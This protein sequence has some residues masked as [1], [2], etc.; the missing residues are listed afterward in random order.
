[1]DAR[2]KIVVRF[3]ATID[4]MTIDLETTGQA[5]AQRFREDLNL[6]ITE[7]T[8]IMSHTLDKDA[9]HIVAELE[10]AATAGTLH[11]ERADV[12]MAKVD[13]MREHKRF[14]YNWAHVMLTTRLMEVLRTLAWRLKDIVRKREYTGSELQRLAAE[15]EDR[16][17]IKLSNAPTGILFLEGMILAR[18]K[19]VHNGG[20]VWETVSN[21]DI[22]M[23][24]GEE[25]WKPKELDQDFK[26]R[27]GE[28][29]DGDRITS[30]EEVFGT[31]TKK[32]L[33]FT[34]WVTGQFDEFANLLTLPT[35]SR[36]S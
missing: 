7:T 14:V 13:N 11:E 3:D 21:P 33:A 12:E 15:F 9:N 36:A 26:E 17:E 2:I 23:A 31:N 34:E 35:G 19:I 16:F 18:N 10:R 22:I 20:M 32:A 27:F 25:P 24:E 6:R 1:L 29:V 4:V 30:T 8:R 5:E 28:Y